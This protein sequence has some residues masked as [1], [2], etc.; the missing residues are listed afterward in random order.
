MIL[1]LLYHFSVCAECFPAQERGCA[2]RRGAFSSVVWQSSTA[3]AASHV[4]HASEGGVSNNRNEQKQAGAIGRLPIIIRF[5]DFTEAS[6]ACANSG[7][8]KH[9]H[10]L[11]KEMRREQIVPN[12]RSYGK[13]IEAAAKAA[14]LKDAEKWFEE[15]ESVSDQIGQA[16]YIMLI[17]A[18]ARERDVAAAERWLKRLADSGQPLD[19]VAFHGVMSAAAAAR[20]MKTSSTWLQK[21]CD[22]NIEPNEMTLIVVAEKLAEAG[23]IHA[24]EEW[25][26]KAI[27]QSQ[28]VLATSQVIL[29]II[30]SAANDCLPVAEQLLRKITLDLSKA[31]TCPGVSREASDLRCLALK[32]MVK[33]HL[34]RGNQESV[35]RW[36]QA[37]RCANC[38]K[39]V[40]RKIYLEM[41]KTSAANGKLARAEQIF[42]DAR[43]AGFN[44]LHFFSVM[45]DAAA[46]C[47][48]LL[49][50]EKWFE[51]A[52]DAGL[53]PDLV[54]FTSMV[55]AAC[56]AGDVRA[57]EYWQGRTQTAGFEPNKV[58]LSTLVKGAAL[59][60]RKDKALRW[61]SRAS[62]EFGPDLVMLNCVIDI[63]ARD[64][65]T[66]HDAEAIL[67]ND[68]ISKSLQPDER[69]FG[70]I[71]NAYAEKGNFER[72]SAYFRQMV[73]LH[74]IPPSVI[75]YNQL[76]KACAR[77][78]PPLA[79]EAEKL[80]DELMAL[81]AEQRRN[82]FKARDLR[83]TRITLKSLGRCVGARRLSQICEA[84]AGRCSSL[85]DSWTIV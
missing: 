63:H 50:A 39:D 33:M 58:M 82:K 36:L 21:M 85:V 11:Y 60:G 18:A 52:L 62:E 10:E 20:D 44:D 68:I 8:H 13:L 57:A 75:Q 65:E 45:V 16:P 74:H 3:T 81:D 83:P 40:F 67:E 66:I 84:G 26:N 34:D 51:K 80:F 69:S 17:D 56:R 22:S 24:A 70:P 7:S 6:E 30:R 43:H 78:R 37:T 73:D 59:A 72:A 12:V 42:S 35:E 49:A 41:L 4:Q 23:D 28:Y 54:L 64:P 27:N 77:C 71:I 25:L 48:D 9:A 46:K 55:D 47:K 29:S 53:E 14:S 31:K 61:A 19:I 1:Y 15:L 5:I 76:L 2:P 32:E 79:R 38:D